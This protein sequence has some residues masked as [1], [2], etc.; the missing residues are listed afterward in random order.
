MDSGRKQMIPWILISY[1]LKNNQ[2]N[3]ENKT[4]CEGCESWRSR[5]DQEHALNTLLGNKEEEF[6]S[7]TRLF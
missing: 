7:L 6:S 5:K 4:L 1:F 2:T 3:T